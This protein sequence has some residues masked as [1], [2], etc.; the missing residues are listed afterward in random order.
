LKIIGKAEKITVSVEKRREEDEMRNRKGL[1]VE[2]GEE[3]KMISGRDEKMRMR[4]IRDQ[5]RRGK[6]WKGK[7]KS[8]RKGR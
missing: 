6:G 8:N 4:K 2:G 7:E 3:E 1:E 5:K